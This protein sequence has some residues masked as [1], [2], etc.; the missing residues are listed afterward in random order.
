LLAHQRLEGLKHLRLRALRLELAADGP[1]GQLDRFEYV[2]AVQGPSVDEE[3]ASL[4][5]LAR[6]VLRAPPK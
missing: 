1:I 3:L 4:E 2:P 6:H 5:R